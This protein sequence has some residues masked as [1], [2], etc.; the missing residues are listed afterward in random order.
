MVNSEPTEKKEYGAG[1]S[2]I[3]L[4]DNGDVTVCTTTGRKT[5]NNI[6]SVFGI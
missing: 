6:M 1:Q 2:R 5:S 4:T 3:N